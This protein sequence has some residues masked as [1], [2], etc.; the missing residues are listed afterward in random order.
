MNKFMCILAGLLLSFA[1][2]AQVYD[3]VRTIKHSGLFTDDTST[4]L[5]GNFISTGTMEIRDNKIIRIF[6]TCESSVCKDYT[7]NDQLLGL[8][9]SGKAAIIFGD[10]GDLATITILSLSP[11][12]IIMQEDTNNHAYRIDEYMFRQ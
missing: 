2:Q 11:T 7:L 5:N 8:H 9:S 12:L 6:H 4:T 3:L 10:S 1:A